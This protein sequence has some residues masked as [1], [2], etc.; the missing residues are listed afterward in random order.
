[1]T[2]DLT[3]LRAEIIRA[4]ARLREMR[5]TLSLAESKCPHNREKQYWSE[6]ERHSRQATEYVPD[7]SNP[8]QQG[9]HIDYP[10]KPVSRTK[11]YWTRRCRLCGKVEE[12]SDTREVTTTVPHF[13]GSGV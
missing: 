12:T 1:M 2:T 5:T 10:E 4:D 6:P 3:S 8:S 11:F 13:G 9:I 7:Y